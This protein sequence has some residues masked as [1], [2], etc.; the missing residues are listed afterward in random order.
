MDK[1]EKRRTTTRME[2][3]MTAFG[4]RILDSEGDVVSV[5]LND[6]LDVIDF[7]DSLHWS[8][9]FLWATGNLGED[10]SMPLFERDIFKSENGLF[11]SWQE[12]KSLSNKFDQVIDLTLIGCKNKNFLRRYKT[13]REKYDNCDVVIKMIDSSYWEIYAKDECLIKK[14]K[15]MFNETEYLSEPD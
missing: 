15:E 5:N 9:L 14:V 6:I 2:L 7:G 11:I 4:I 13:D 3:L 8:I 1:I 12:L 10:K